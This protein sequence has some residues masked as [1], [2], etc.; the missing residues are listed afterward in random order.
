[1]VSLSVYMLLG[2]F[3]RNTDNRNALGVAEMCSGR[4]GDVGIVGRLQPRL[5]SSGP[6]MTPDFELHSWREYSEHVNAILPKL[7]HY[8]ILLDLLEIPLDLM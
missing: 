8:Y 3:A 7:V 1:M 5:N 4:V 2:I 6:V